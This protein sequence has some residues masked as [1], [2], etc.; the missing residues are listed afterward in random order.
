MNSLVIIGLVI[1]GLALAVYS[2]KSWYNW[3]FNNCRETLVWD[4]FIIMSGI[5]TMIETSSKF[6][7]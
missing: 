3:N 7:A 1:Y 5:F 6:L 4:I 2:I